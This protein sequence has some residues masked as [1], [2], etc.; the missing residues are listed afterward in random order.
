[1]MEGYARCNVCTEKNVRYCDGCFSNTEFDSVEV[2]KQA[3]K[4]K[5][6]SQRAEVGRLA[7][8]AASAFAALAAAQQ[9][10]VRLG[11]KLDKLTE[12]QSSMLRKELAALDALDEVTDP[13]SRVAVSLDEQFDWNDP[14]LYDFSGDLSGFGGTGEQ[15]HG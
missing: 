2:Q 11:E 5:V 1:M 3:V 15:V 12:K 6:R 4:D 9:E 7:A 8:A 14:S 13:D 10:E